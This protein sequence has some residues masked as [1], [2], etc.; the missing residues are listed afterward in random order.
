MT[1]TNLNLILI[2]TIIYVLISITLANNSCYDSKSRKAKRCIPDFRNVAYGLRSVS[3]SNTCGMNGERTEYCVQSSLHSQD[4]E[5]SSEK[6]KKCSYCDSQDPRRRHPSDYLTDFHSQGT[7]TW[8]QSETMYEDIQYPKSV[9]ITMDLERTYEIT[10]IKLIFH[11]PRPES[12]A[13]YKKTHKNSDWIPYQFYSASCSETYGLHAS[14][15]VKRGNEAIALCSNEYSDI[16]PLTGSP[17]AFSTLEFRPSS[18]Q[19]DSSD[20]LKEWVTASSIKIVLN[21]LNTFGD[22]IFNDKQVLQSYYYAISDIS[23]GGR[24]KCNGHASNCAKDANGHHK[25]VCE[26]NTAGDDCERCAPFYNALPWKPATNIDAHEC[27]PCNCN[28]LSDECVFDEVLYESSGNGGRCVNC[29]GNRDGPRC[30]YCKEGFFRLENDI[31]CTDCGCNPIGS[32]SKQCDP[33]GKCKCRP[34]I[35]G[36]KCDQCAPNHFGMSVDG[37]KACSC[38]VNGSFDSPPYCNPIDGNCR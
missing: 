22:E 36:E 21:R 37:C 29:R 35:T 12:F 19:F 11:S 28:G 6:S 32:E 3:V 10:Y 2:T 16:S 27:Q 33:S 38:N 9:N 7:I 31:A 26:H 1:K 17:V 4:E 23:I 13:I 8:W 18:Y 34:G 30:E 5:S 14:N 15:E 24:C 20:E 25:C